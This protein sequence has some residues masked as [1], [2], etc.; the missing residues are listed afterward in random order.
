MTDRSPNTPDPRAGRRLADA[1]SAR[2]AS[3]AGD[4][5]DQGG[6]ALAG[7]LARATLIAV[8]GAAALV[9]VG[10]VLAS[11]FGLLFVAGIT[12]ALAGLVLS[13]AAAPLDDS[14]RPV[15]RRT[16]AWLAVALALGAVAVGAVITWLIARA[17]GGTLELVDYLLTTFGPFVP[18]EAVIAAVAAWWGAT[19]GPVQR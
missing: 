13:R 10:A 7:P 11:T 9:L 19:T 15:P 1:P 5:R 16:L 4:A 8:A 18:A 6:S 3:A 14:R 12:G 17:E 2:Y